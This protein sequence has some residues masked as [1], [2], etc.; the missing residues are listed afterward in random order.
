MAGSSIVSTSMAPSGSRC[1]CLYMLDPDHFSFRAVGAMVAN[2]L[3]EYMGE[4]SRSRT[5]V[6]D[7]A[8]GVEIFEQTLAGGSMHVRRRDGCAVADEL[9]RILVRRG[10]A[11]VGP[12]DLIIGVV[13]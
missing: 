10:W 4:I 3:G 1:T 9:R 12:I 8:A 5:D 7:S 6:Q 2:K 11:V 13:S